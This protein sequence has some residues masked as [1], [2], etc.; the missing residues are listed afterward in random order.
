M[1][2][3]TFLIL[4]FIL[5][6]GLRLWLGFVNRSANDDHISVINHIVDKNVIPEKEDCWSCYQPKLYYLVA[7]GFIKKFHYKMK[8]RR[9]ITAQV[10]N[11]FFGFLIILIFWNFLKKQSMDERSRLTLLAFFALNPCL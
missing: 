4:I 8:E 1:K 7:S 10:L 9:I 3:R 2:Q 5:S 11:V 6:T